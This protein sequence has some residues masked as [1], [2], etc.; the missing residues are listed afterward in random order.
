MNQIKTPITYYGGKQKMLNEIL[1]KIP[2]HK[3]YV[4]PFF[5]G[6]AVFFAKPPSEAEIV[7]DSNSKLVTFYRTMRD[8]FEGLKTL[9]DETFHSRTQHREADAI[10][11]S[12]IT[13]ELKTAWSV[14]V[15]TNMSFGAMIGGGFGYDRGGKCALKLS[16]KKENF[17]AAYK[18]RLRKVTIENNDVLKIIKVY[19]SPET[20]FYLDPPYVSANQGHY[21]G[22]TAENFRDLL[23]VCAN[24]QGKFLLSTY[25]EE[26][27]LEEFVPNNGWK[28]ERHEKSLAVDGRRK[29]NKI[30]IECLTWNY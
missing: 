23:N 17:T 3:V 25:P 21:A 6:G 14:W 24:M 1:P 9:V 29:E 8:D 22:Y 28:T 18:E 15:Q 20:F 5:G 10:Y 12:D 7:N 30:K 16:N 4:E 13:D 19:D 2:K 27:L 11:K 26:M